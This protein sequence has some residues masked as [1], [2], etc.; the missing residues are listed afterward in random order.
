M[1][2]HWVSNE[3][4][5]TDRRGTNKKGT[6]HHPNIRIADSSE[7]DIFDPFQEKLPKRGNQKKW[8]F[9]NTLE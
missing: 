3:M 9:Y 4:T 6:Q 7:V 8:S 2:I 5:V 1:Y